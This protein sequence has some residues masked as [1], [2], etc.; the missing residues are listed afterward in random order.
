[1]KVDQLNQICI[2]K[3]WATD[4]F[5]DLFNE[6]TY[7]KQSP[8]SETSRDKFSDTLSL[9]KRNNRKLK[10]MNLEVKIRSVG[11]IFDYLGNI[12]LAQEQNPEKVVTIVPSSTV[13]QKYYPGLQT[14]APL[15]KVYKNKNDI[16]MAT[17]VTYKGDTYSVAQS[18]GS[19]SKMVL[20]Y[21][22]TLITLAKVPGSIPGILPQ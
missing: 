16:K 22:A 9:H 18:D 7:C 17:S 2:N 4:L 13:L 1:V 6:N 14:P 10:N 20:E 12:M 5:G 3:Y 8:K 15:F 19:Y 11:N 21:L